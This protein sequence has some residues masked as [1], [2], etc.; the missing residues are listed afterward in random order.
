MM[1]GLSIKIKKFI[2]GFTLVETIVVTGIVGIT[3]P[4]LFTT[5]FVVMQQQAQVYRLSEVKRQ[6]D[7]ALA[8]VMNALQSDAGMLYDHNNNEVCNTTSTTPVNVA[9]FFSPSGTGGSFQLVEGKLLK[10]G[11][12]ITDNKTRVEYLCVQCV[13]TNMNTTP[14]VDVSFRISSALTGSSRPEDKIAMDYFTKVK[15]RNQ[16]PVNAQIGTFITGATLMDSTTDVPVPA[17]TTI[18]NNAVLPSGPYTFRFNTSGAV[19]SVRMVVNG[20]TTIIDNS[21]PFSLSDTNGNYN[22]SGLAD[23]VYSIVA[24]PYS[25]INATGVA[26][27]P[28]TLN[29]SL[30]SNPVV[31]PAVTSFSLIAA[32]DSDTLPDAAV[33]RHDPIA[34]GAVI[35]QGNYSIRANTNPAVVGSVRF[36]VEGQTGLTFIDNSA[37]Y[38][39]DNESGGDYAV[40]RLT[41]GIRTITATPFSGANATGTPGTSLTIV[42]TVQ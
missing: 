14:F 20:T 25:R 15:L 6:G 32:G 27:A 40:W 3:L 8:S 2:G 26:G 23:G 38:A 29:F 5:F 16:R 28:Y 12:E 7:E 10:D 24:V 31:V 35:A 17:Y 18:I 34:S 41:Q 39:L 37:P 19:A 22:P 4:L 30:R 1:R 21:P 36:Q 11:A 13:R 9:R 42:I 33:C